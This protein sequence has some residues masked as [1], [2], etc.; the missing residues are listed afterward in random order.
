VSLGLSKR[1]VLA[2]LQQAFVANDRRGCASVV[3][4]C[5][6]TTSLGLQKLA[7]RS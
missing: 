3:I 6:A 5:V 2:N 4:V 7:F 1:F